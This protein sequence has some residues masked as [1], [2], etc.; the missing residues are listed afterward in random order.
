MKKLT[1]DEFQNRLRQLRESGL[2]VY[3]DDEYTTVN[4]SM[5]FYCS[6]GHRWSAIVTTVLN[7]HSGCPYCCGRLPIVGETDLWTTRPDIASLLLNPE[8]GYRLKDG[9]QIKT[10]FVCPNCNSILKNKIVRNVSRRGLRCPIC[11]DGVSYPN[12]F[13]R[14]MLQQLNIDNV[15]YEWNP[16]W[17]KPYFYDNYFVYNNIK[18][19]LEMD[20]GIG[21]GNVIYKTQ[22][23]DVC[24]F[25]R[26]MIKDNL[27]LNHGV[28][29]IRIDCNYCN[30]NRFEYIKNNIIN[31]FLANIFDLSMIDWKK[32]DESARSSMIYYVA[33]MY[34]NGMTVKEII[35]ITGYG[36]TTVHKWLKH[37][38]KIDLCIYNPEESKL[39]S[40][41]LVEK[42]INQYNKS[43]IFIS[44]YMSQK[45]AKNQTGISD[46]T[47]NNVLKGRNKFAGGFLWF[48]ADDPDQPDKSKIIPNNTKL[49]KE[50]S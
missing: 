31:S 22:E 34:N 2:D 30:N 41:K 12:K 29:V 45:D 20:G 40:R 33:K 37:A 50:V 48:Y 27:A 39:R 42:K 5:E 25:Q 1:N 16:Y 17:L 28:N 9:S 7:N 6:K 24:G 38:T 18:Y 11:G 3:T 4:D 49:I 15:E 14:A 43:E 32:C 10:D 23:K 8:D 13:A 44:T 47:I 19:V 21:H 46:S 26:D 35:N 36:R